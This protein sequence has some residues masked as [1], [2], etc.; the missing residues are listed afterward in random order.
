MPP[1]TEDYSGKCV[2][3]C[4]EGQHIVAVHER[5]QPCDNLENAIITYRLVCRECTWDN[6]PQCQGTLEGVLR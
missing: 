2:H 5:G 3:L 1:L 4:L 6:V